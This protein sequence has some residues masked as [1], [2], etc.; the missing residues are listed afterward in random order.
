MPMRTF[1]ILIIFTLIACST[2]IEIG[3]PS[4]ATG[5]LDQT[6]VMVD[7]GSLDHEPPLVENLTGSGDYYYP[8][9]QGLETRIITI[10]HRSGS[11]TFISFVNSEAKSMH[12]MVTFPLSVTGGNL[13]LAQIVMP[14]GNMD[15]PFGTDSIVPLT[16]FGGYTLR[17]SENQMSGEPWSG[18][19]IITLVPSGK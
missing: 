13:R 7:S 11:G 18:D 1:I 17:F 10:K 16:Q 15:G 9:F 3:L 5:S 4:T 12:V 14:D 2:S 19:A 6:G 8:I